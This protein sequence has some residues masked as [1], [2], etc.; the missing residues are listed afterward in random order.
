[1]L[2]KFEVLSLSLVLS[3]FIINVIVILRTERYLIDVINIQNY[4]L[5]MLR[6]L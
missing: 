5:E 3:Q 2:S 6:T 4:N 1:M